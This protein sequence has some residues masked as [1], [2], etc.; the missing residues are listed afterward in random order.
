[1]GQPGDKDSFKF[2]LNSNYILIY[3]KT[4]F[5]VCCFFYFFIMITLLLWGEKPLAELAKKAVFITEATI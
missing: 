3:V 4:F 2:K 1:M 5:F